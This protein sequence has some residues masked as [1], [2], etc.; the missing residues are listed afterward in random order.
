MTDSGHRRCVLVVCPKCGADSGIAEFAK[1]RRAVFEFTAGGAWNKLADNPHRT[2]P[3]C[4]FAGLTSEFDC[5]IPDRVAKEAPKEPEH[6][7]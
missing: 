1:E 5:R 7:N 2:C 6:G 3:L 4:G